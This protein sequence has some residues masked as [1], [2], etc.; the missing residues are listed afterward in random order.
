[1]LNVVVYIL[2]YSKRYE[3]CRAVCEASLWEQTA[4]IGCKPAAA[5]QVALCN[6]ISSNQIH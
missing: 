3:V 1:M 4:F 6:R 2:R 5:L